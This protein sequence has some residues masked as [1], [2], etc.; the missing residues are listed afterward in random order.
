[1]L[2]HK[3]AY[4]IYIYIRIYIYYYW[5]GDGIGAHLLEFLL[6]LQV[7]RLL[8]HYLRQ[9]G[10]NGNTMAHAVGAHGRALPR[11]LTRCALPPSLRFSAIGGLLQ[12]WFQLP[13]ENK[14]RYPRV[15]DIM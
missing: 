7:F 3:H 12:R 1:M 11:R 13:T 5:A 14:D 4:Y 8:L 6:Q 2:L 9:S 10:W 15:Y